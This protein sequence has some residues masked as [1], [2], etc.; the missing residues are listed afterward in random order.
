MSIHAQAQGILLTPFFKF[1]IPEDA[2]SS[3]FRRRAAISICILISLVIAVTLFS[4]Q[5]IKETVTEEKQIALNVN[6]DAINQSLEA[7][8]DT[9]HFIINNLAEQQQLIN[10]SERLT[11]INNIDDASLAVTTDAFR[12]FITSKYT[13]P[14]VIDFLLLDV[15]LSTIASLDEREANVYNDTFIDYQ[16]ILRQALTGQTVLIPP[17]QSAELTS[18]VLYF[19]TSVRNPNGDIIAILVLREDPAVEFNNFFTMGRTQTRETYAIDKQGRMLSE[20]LF[21]LQLDDIKLLSLGQSS[22]G[23]IEIRDPGSDLT[24]GEFPTTLP[25]LWPLTVMAKSATQ[26]I[27]GENLEGYRDYRGVPVIGEWLWNSKLGI[28]LTTEVDLA[29]V[30]ASYYSARRPLLIVLGFILLVITLVGFIGSL[31]ADRALAVLTRSRE[32]LQAKVIE[33]TT[34]LD[35]SNKKMAAIINN[36]A[37]AIIVFDQEGKLLTF[38][39]SAEN[40]FGYSIEEAIGSSFFNLLAS[41][42]GEDYHDYIQSIV[43]NSEQGISSAAHEIIGINSMGLEF[44]ID[45]AF[46]IITSNESINFTAIVRDIT[47]R[48]RIFAE[49][50]QAK[51]MAEAA[52]LAKSDF[53]ANMSHEIR[54]PMNAIMGMSHLALQTD[55]APKQRDYIQKVDLSAKILLKI[56]NDILD[57][58]KIEAGKLAI[59]EIDFCLEDVLD[60]MTTLIGPKVESKEVELLFEIDKNVPLDLIGDPLR[61]GQILLNLCGNAIKFTEFGEIIVS[62]R[63]VESDQ[64]SALLQFAVKDTGIGMTEAQCQEL[65][66]SFSQTDTSITRKYGGTGLGLTISKKLSEL[67]GG[68]I[69][70]ESTYQ[71]GSTFY[72]TSKFGIQASPQPRLIFDEE[73]LQGLKILIVDDNAR[74]REILSI[75]SEHLGMVVD[76]AEDGIKALTIITQ[77]EQAHCPYDIVLM[78]MKMPEINGIDCIKKFSDLPITH[79]QAVI[80]VTSY[81]RSDVIIEAESKGVV[82]DSVLSKPVTPKKLLKTIVESLQQRAN[83]KPRIIDNPLRTPPKSMSGLHLLVVEDNDFNK[84]VATGLLGNLGIEV[85]IACHGQEAL[86]MLS[87]DNDYHGILMDVQMPIMDGYTATLKIRQQSKYKNIPIIAMTAN[88]MKSDKDKC[89]KCGMNDQISKPIDPDNLF[90]TIQQWISLDPSTL[91]QPPPNQS[92]KSITLQDIEKIVEI[93]TVKGLKY[94][95]GN[96]TTYIK[97]LMKFAERHNTDVEHVR[98]YMYGGHLD[99]AR[100]QAHTLKAVAATIGALALSQLAANLEDTLSQTNPQFTE[101]D[102]FELEAKLNTIISNLNTLLKDHQRNT[103]NT[104]AAIESISIQELNNK[105]DLLI[106]SLRQFNTEAESLASSLLNSFKNNEANLILSTILI[107]LDEFDFETA[108]TEALKLNQIDLTKA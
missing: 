5:K 50:E 52:T 27:N 86:D 7:W 71:Q 57:F 32:E 103:D 72:V 53:L 3:R 106:D 9:K 55:L 97:L 43:A 47:E 94:A 36:A 34:D 91:Q 13:S 30:M 33:R 102:L 46:G 42:Y 6:L 19:A 81:S 79:P 1:F 76:V 69:W 98:N 39:P 23:N 95:D 83:Q 16:S 56:L 108:L 49:L 70:M 84:E 14:S 44:P 68:N 58:S 2:L 105:K 78:D 22:V 64:A 20:S 4:L 99:D 74:S 12:E 85:S 29:E 80:M 60:N 54:T 17:H 15:D 21:T 100:R 38:S 31:V 59:E 82:L 24:A 8:Y 48:K 89:L 63:L 92:A 93:D 77:Q 18:P 90:K 10:I 87:V 26:G 37:D 45:V 88:A 61:L 66:Q 73:E 35:D 75:M 96:L 40:I 28:G 65:F 62:I 11:G 101:A 25:N 51:E 41:P 107:S 67:M 104:D